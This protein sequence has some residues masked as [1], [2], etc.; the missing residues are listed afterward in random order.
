MVWVVPN[1]KLWLM[2]HPLEVVVVVLTPPF[3]LAALQP[4]RALRLL[5]LVRLV[6]LFPLIRRLRE[7]QETVAQARAAAGD[8]EGEEAGQAYARVLTPALDRALSQMLREASATARRE[9][10]EE[11]F[12]AH[13]VVLGERSQELMIMAEILR[14]DLEDY[15][16]IDPRFDF[17]TAVHAYSRALENA[18][19]EHLFEPL[20]NSGAP[21]PADTGSSGRDRSLTVLRR[22]RDDEITPELGTMAFCLKN[23]ASG[24]IANAPDN[25]FASLLDRKLINRAEFCSDFSSE[26][27]RYAEEFRNRAAH[28]E[29]MTLE[30]C[31]QARARLMEEPVRLLHLLM[32]SLRSSLRAPSAGDEHVRPESVQ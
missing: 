3:F 15:S 32:S 6:R 5:R 2:R 27:M 10:L 12:G 28:V 31:D 8:L 14:G 11:S 23:V 4:V 17:A 29:R 19:L 16:A 21:L 18:V 7:P 13:W 24:T 9:A 1:K 20:R 25:G 26:L 30:E 22:L